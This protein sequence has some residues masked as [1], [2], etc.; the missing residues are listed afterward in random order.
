MDKSGG[1]N[2]WDIA[3]TVK[4]IE[5]G[6]AAAPGWDIYHL[7]SLFIQW[8]NGLDQRPRNPGGMFVSFCKRHTSE[9]EL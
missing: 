6:R 7:E 9:N 5:N 3:L 1:N 8:C 2:R 4:A